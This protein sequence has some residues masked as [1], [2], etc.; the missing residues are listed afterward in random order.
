M[1]GTLV[2]GTVSRRRHV[3]KEPV[4]KAELRSG[5]GLVGDAHAGPGDRQVSLRAAESIR[6]QT[7]AFAENAADGRPSFCPKARGP[8][9]PGA[10]TENLTTEGLDLS[11]L[12]AGTRLTVG[13]EVVL[14]VTQTGRE[15]FRY[16]EVFRRLG[17]CAMPRQTAFAR[18]VRGGVVR[19]DDTVQVRAPDGCPGR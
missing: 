11:T 4:A 7:R 13:S 15:C 19:P 8:L 12:A 14:E 2:S 17:R 18:V 10:L 6:T 1:T 9:G 16:C 3:A 5:H